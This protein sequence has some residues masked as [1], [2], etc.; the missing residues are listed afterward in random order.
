MNDFIKIT[1]LT[2]LVVFTFA[3][4]DLHATELLLDYNVTYKT[5][6]KSESVKRSI[7]Q[8]MNLKG[9]KNDALLNHLQTRFNSGDSIQFPFK[10]LVEI[11]D[12]Q[13]TAFKMD[14]YYPPVSNAVIYHNTDFPKKKKIICDSN[15]I[16]EFIN[17]SYK[18]ENDEPSIKKNEYKPDGLNSCDDFFLHCFLESQFMLSHAIIENGI[19]KAEKDNLSITRIG[20]KL[21]IFAASSSGRFTRNAEFCNNNGIYLLNHFTRMC[22][23]NSKVI[24]NE[25]IFNLENVKIVEED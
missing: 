19:Q 8:H 12:N 14:D 17:H 15:Y 2:G 22:G 16:T 3:P 7:Q 10:I 4:H 20:D 25:V 13:I 9:V 18:N 24:E 11:N 21:N 5:M 6:P 1:I 23:L